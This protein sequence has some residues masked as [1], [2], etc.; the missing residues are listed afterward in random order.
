MKTL[1]FLIAISFFSIQIGLSCTFAGRSISRFDDDEYVFIGIVTG[2][3]KDVAFDE[4]KEKKSVE[5]ISKTFLGE[6]EKPPSRAVGLIIKVK[7]SVYLPKS[8]SEFEVFQYNLMADCS[9]SSVSSYKLEREF[10]I[11]SEVR[12]IAKEAVLLTEPS[13]GRIRLEDRPREQGQI[14]INSDQN[15]NRL[16]SSESVFSYK[17][18]IYDMNKDSASKYL[19]PSFE[20][21]KDLLRLKKASTQTERNV[22]LDRLF[23]APLYGELEFRD[24]L[25]L[26]ATNETEA[27]LTY[28]TF[29]KTRDPEGYKAYQEWEKV[30]NDLS[31]LG[32]QRSDAERALRVAFEE[33]TSFDSK[34]FL[35]KCIEILGRDKKKPE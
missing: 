29:L 15:V 5:A 21:R 11:N 22:I 34:N 12:V 6:P 13:S 14:I 4:K 32:Y 35:Q 17:D 23:Y 8:G 30:V 1:G 24:V 7:E 27:R 28:E 20:I 26:Y 16:S 18:F 33:G 10:P 25:N 2:Y 19:L 3:T 31:K 9:L